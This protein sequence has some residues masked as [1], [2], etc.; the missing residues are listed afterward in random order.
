[1][2]T[3]ESGSKVF[4]ILAFIF[5]GELRAREVARSL[6]WDVKAAASEAGLKIIST[7][8]VAVDAKGKTHVHETGHGG[9]GAGIGAATGGALSLLGGPAG[10]LLWAVG[11]AVIGGLAGQHVGHAV[12]VS[13]LKALGQQMAPNTSAL[14][15][16]TE[17]VYAES[18]ISDMQGYN[19]TIVTLTVS[20]QFSGELTTMVAG[21]VTGPDAG[22]GTDKT[23]APAA[24][25]A[26]SSAE[27][28]SADQRAE[29]AAGSESG[30][31]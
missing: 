10:L 4:S 3:Q 31:S 19:A 9:W 24:E 25:T 8:T 11:G 21:E 28:A 2:S 13:Q 26:Q 22:K 14:L 20:D 18:I 7:A 15:V 30:Q 17:D 23:G 12:P 1:V 29:A 6:K 5:P 16:L 27:P